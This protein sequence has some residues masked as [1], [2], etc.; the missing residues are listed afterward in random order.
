MRT[1]RLSKRSEMPQIQRWI[2]IVLIASTLGSVAS[3]AASAAESSCAADFSELTSIDALKAIEA[4]ASPNAGNLDRHRLSSLLYQSKDKQGVLEAFEKRLLPKLSTENDPGVLLSYALTFKNY[5]N[6]SSLSERAAWVGVRVRERM[7]QLIQESDPQTAARAQ[8]SLSSYFPGLTLEEDQLLKKGLEATLTKSSVE[9]GVLKFRA[10]NTEFQLPYSVQ[11]ELERR[12]ALPQLPFQAHIPMQVIEHRHVTT[13]EIEVTS[14]REVVQLL[15]DRFHA[16][17]SESFGPLRTRPLSSRLDHSHSGQLV[18]AEGIATKPSDFTEVLGN[19][20]D[21]RQKWNDETSRSYVVVHQRESATYYDTPDSALQQ[22]GVAVRIKTWRPIGESADP[23]A[24]PA[25]ALFLKRNARSNPGDDAVFTDRR[26]YIL[27]LVGTATEKS[28][29]DVIRSAVQALLEKEKLPAIDLSGLKP[30]VEVE[31]ERYGFDLMWNGQVK[32]GFVTVDSF[33][34]TPSGGAAPALP[35]LQW[36]MELL[37]QWKPLFDAKKSE[38]TKFFSGVEE[39][40]HGK[41]DPAP[42]YLHQPARLLPGRINAALLKAEYRASDTPFK[43]KKM[44]A[45]FLGDDLSE[46]VV[47]LKSAEER[48]R[49]QVYPHDGKLFDAYGIPVD[50]AGRKVIY[51]MDA[52]GNFFLNRSGASLRYHSSFLAGEPVAAAG[53]IEVQ[54][55]VVKF[56]DNNSGHYAPPREFLEQAVQRLR[57]LGIQVPDI[58]IRDVGSR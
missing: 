30:A 43:T 35:S 27:P 36:E 15:L 10:G 48:A 6:D 33:T 42:K 44:G 39:S 53:E 58:G 49:Y 2:A 32:V 23:H 3:P 51:V 8:A 22:A 12:V 31:N 20:L 14:P 18:S 50:S 21:L 19:R 25:R 28:E 5:G 45:G 56:I 16:L 1:R 17:P 55:G 46:R 40:F 57:R 11:P 13:Q 54:N 7:R 4:L 41:L 34:P 26:E 52:Q 9:Q 37:P 38:F 29:S 47:Y 24:Q